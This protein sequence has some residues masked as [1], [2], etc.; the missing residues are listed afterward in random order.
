MNRSPPE[1]TRDLHHESI[2]RAAACGV[3]LS[4]PAGSQRGGVIWFDNQS[5][6]KTLTGASFSPF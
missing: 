3:R 2:P 6:S 4:S 1:T 5:A